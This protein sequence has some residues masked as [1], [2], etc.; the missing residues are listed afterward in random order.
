MVIYR[1]DLL[2]IG[3]V[4]AA[5]L[6]SKCVEYWTGLQFP[7]LYYILLGLGLG[8][9]LPPVTIV[10]IKEKKDDSSEEDTQF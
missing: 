8:F 1:I 3:I 7:L 10:R 5:G 2:H 4:I 9:I 6:L